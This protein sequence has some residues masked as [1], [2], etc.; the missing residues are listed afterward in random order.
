MSD[1]IADRI[2]ELTAEREKG[3]RALSEIQADI[4]ALEAERERLREQMLRIE[5]ALQVLG[6]LSDKARDDG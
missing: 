1:P 5:G 3:R 6:E 4:A 2:A